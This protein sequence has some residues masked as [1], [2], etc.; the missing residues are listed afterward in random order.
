M[1]SY[2]LFS[3]GGLMLRSLQPLELDPLDELEL[4][5]TLVGM[6]RRAYPPQPL[7]RRSKIFNIIKRFLQL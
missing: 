1:T 2:I 3:K 6:I 7:A 5:A 4:E